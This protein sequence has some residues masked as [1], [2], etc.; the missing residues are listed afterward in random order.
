MVFFFHFFS[1]FF[2]GGCDFFFF[3]NYRKGWADF[4]GPSFIPR[5]LQPIN[6]EESDDDKK[7]T[8]EDLSD[9]PCILVL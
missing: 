4:I 2:F 8:Y 7:E 6:D 1:C 5:K 3:S 9:L